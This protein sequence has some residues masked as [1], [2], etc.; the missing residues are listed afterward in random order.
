MYDT[1][2]F[3]IERAGLFGANS[4]DIK[5]YLSNVT[6]WKN[7]NGSNYTGNAENYKITVS[8]KGIISLSGS[9]SKYYFGDNLQSL[10][11]R[12]TKQA[13]DKLSDLI[14]LDFRKAK[15]TRFDIAGNILTQRQ[16]ADYYPYLGSKQYFERVQATT[17]T[18]Y[19][20]NHQKQLCFYN[21]AKQAAT[22]KIP[23]PTELQNENLLRY[24][25]RYSNHINKQFKT[26]V[27]ATML[28]EEA[29]YS[30]V[31]QNWYNEFNSIE[32]TKSNNFMPNVRTIKQ[33]ERAAFARLLQ[34]A[35]QPF[36]DE[37][38][39]DCK[40]NKRFKH[41]ADYSK[42]KAKLKKLIVASDFEDNSDLIKELKLKIYEIARDAR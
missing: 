10:T 40:A 39:S 22:K 28:Y 7:K 35:G 21:K 13:I 24:E 11:R 33:A 27:T 29:F 18:L 14:H 38:I 4:F 25:L 26:D 5:R 23:I 6:E 42:L 19:Y 32:T 36:I 34:N 37:I 3:K 1:V 20:N 8:E 15:V 30:L 41:R 9:L 2:N 16:P 31:P 12:D 17:N